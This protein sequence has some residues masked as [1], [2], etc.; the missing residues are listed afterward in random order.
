MIELMGDSNFRFMTNHVY[1]NLAQ[2]FYHV[3]SQNAELPALKF[4]HR[5][6]SYEELND[7]A[8]S[9]ARLLIKSNRTPPKVVGIINTKSEYG[10]ACMLACLRLGAAYV[11]IDAESPARR[12]TAILG[13]SVP[14]LLVADCDLDPELTEIVPKSVIHLNRIDMTDAKEVAL[15]DMG[16]INGNKPAYIMFTSGST[17]TPKG[18]AISHQSVL[19]FI[20]WSRTRFSITQEDI[21]AQLSPLYFDNSVFDFY[22]ALFTG[23]SLAP[24]SKELLNNPP[25]L[26]KHVTKMQCTIWFSVPSLYVYSLTMRCFCSDY[27]YNIRCFIFGGE[28]FPKVKLKQVFDIY[29][30]T[31]KFINVYGPTEGTCI[32]S[33]YDVRSS[34]FENLDGI[35]PLGTLNPNFGKL[36]LNDD[37]KAKDDEEGELCLIGPNIALGYYNSW[38]LTRE[39]FCN[40]PFESA[41]HERIYKT[42]DIVRY[43]S[44]TGLLEF[45]AR[46]G[47]QIK[48]MGY[49]IELDE[50]EYHLNSLNGVAEAA[51]IYNK[52][53]DGLGKIF[54]AVATDKDSTLSE[55][56]IIT[57]L[58][59]LLPIY[60]IP[61]A[62]ELMA[63]LP[64]NANGKIDRNE[65]K[66][67]KR[68]QFQ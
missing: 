40:N 15:P 48:H 32:C 18:V 6:F 9:I 54:A 21:F 22:T 29:G 19:N 63:T 1:F 45:I 52:R 33:S 47:N 49:R 11:N 30:A 43:S 58:Q 13:V 66:A 68:F 28:G 8:E 62:I 17:G 55:K 46:K 27:L 5:T 41:Y 61:S 37:G 4:E 34:D 31:A 59:S 25:E 35:L 57:S 26:V 67:N 7:L 44:S 24:V 2:M 50:I 56:N 51:V 20:Q 53:G 16:S 36:I 23:A 10:Y 38:E 42:G 12:T 64:K 39:A 14:D 3:S 65:I 60:M